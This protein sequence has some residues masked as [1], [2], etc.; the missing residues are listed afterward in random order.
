MPLIMHIDTG[1]KDGVAL[2]DLN[3]VLVVDSP[4]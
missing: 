4:R 3:V 1:E 2:D